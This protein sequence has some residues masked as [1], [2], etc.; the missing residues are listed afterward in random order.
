M[1]EKVDKEINNGSGPYVFTMN[2]ENYHIVGTLL[3]EHED[4]D[5]TF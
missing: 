2:G 3:T 1:V 5:H 4:W